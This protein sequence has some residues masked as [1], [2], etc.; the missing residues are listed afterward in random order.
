MTTTSSPP[1][2]AIIGC[3]PGGMSFLHALALRRKAL[4]GDEEGLAKLPIVTVYE[5]A[6]EAGGVWRSATTSNTTNNSSTKTVFVAEGTDLVQVVSNDDKPK[7]QKDE[8]TLDTSATSS[9]SSSRSSTPTLPAV[10][11]QTSSSSA[12]NMYEALWTNGPSPAIEFFDYSFQEHFQKPVP[13]FLPRR[14]VLDYLLARYTKNNPSFFDDVQFNTTVEHV[15]YDETIQKFKITTTS[16]QGGT[17]ALFDK[18]IWAAGENGGAK[19][20]TPIRSLLRTNNYL[21]TDVHSCEAGRYL[22]T[23]RDQ[24]ILIIGD[25]AS[26]EDLTLQAI[27]LGAKK[28]YILPRSAE[29]VCSYTASWPG[30]KAQVLWN[31]CITGVSDDGY[32]IRTSTVTYDPL[33]ES[34]TLVEGGR[35]RELKDVRLVIYCT[36]YQANFRMLDPCLCQPFSE[37]Q[38]DDDYLQTCLPKDWRMTENSLTPEVGENVEPA[39]ELEFDHDDFF[40]LVPGIY[41]GLLMENP[42][43]MFLCEGV[44]DMPLHDIDVHAWWLLASMVGDVPIPSL[45]QMQNVQRDMV[46]R[47]MQIPFVRRLLDVNYYQALLD[48]HSTGDGDDED[49]WWDSFHNDNAVALEQEAKQ[50]VFDCHAQDMLEAKYPLQFLDTA[51]GTLNPTCQRLI[52]MLLE[53]DVFRGAMVTTKE[54]KKWLTFRDIDPTNFQSLVTGTPV[55]PLPGHWIDLPDNDTDNTV[56]VEQQQ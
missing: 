56:V 26:A 12:T 33:T 23:V 18:C 55:A 36:G 20:P 27:K 48:A 1:T 10:D 19:V 47:G 9:L 24:K 39:N 43:M 38:Q 44:T 30:R 17:E 16:S 51:T 21:G 34:Q 53:G 29:G 4:E 32:G 31:Q 6:S 28:V 2:V 11:D 49:P 15:M 8:A 42:N 40:Y 45:E 52:Q 5:R 3:G 50:F 13:L 7:E 35:T 46:L 54:T 22:G 14:Q 37:Q 41:K 25:S